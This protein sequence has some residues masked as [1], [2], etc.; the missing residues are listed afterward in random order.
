MSDSDQYP[1]EPE[2]IA[3]ATLGVPDGCTFFAQRVLTK[4]LQALLRRRSVSWVGWG[5][6]RQPEHIVQ[7]ITVRERVPA[8][9]AVHAA[10]DELGLLG[11]SQI[12]YLD[13]DEL[14][15]RN[16]HPLGAAPFD[17]FL[18]LDDAARAVEQAKSWLEAYQEA[19]R[20]Q[21]LPEENPQT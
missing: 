14:Y 5:A 2:R 6:S 18:N 10:L 8:L 13:W 19:F 3:I 21:K 15:W 12:A 17:R 16:V 11:H 9:Q 7:L 20:R 4:A 1:K